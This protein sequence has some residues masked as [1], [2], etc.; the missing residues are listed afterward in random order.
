MLHPLSLLNTEWEYKGSC[1]VRAAP[2]TIMD[3]KYVLLIS[4]AVNFIV[5]SR[6]ALNLA[7]RIT[8]NQQYKY[9]YE[10]KNLHC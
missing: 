2:K 8:P 9:V 5:C 6:S 3:G 10:Y 1:D 4:F 7:I